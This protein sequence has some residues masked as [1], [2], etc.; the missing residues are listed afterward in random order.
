MRAFIR[1]YR[2]LRLPPQSLRADYM[3]TEGYF[4]RRTGLRRLNAV[5]G[6]VR[7]T[8]E[9]E[10]ARTRAGNRLECWG[11]G[12]IGGSNSAGRFLVGSIIN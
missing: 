5:G 6:Y 11:G 7:V 9:H 3:L 10:K 12:L 1:V 4:K 2:T 8:T